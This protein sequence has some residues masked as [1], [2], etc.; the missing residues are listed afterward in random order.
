[1]SLKPLSFFE[2]QAVTDLTAAVAAGNLPAL[3]GFQVEVLNDQV[4]WAKDQLTR[5]A[6][7]LL[8]ATH[9]VAHKKGFPNSDPLVL[10]LTAVV[11][12]GLQRE[13]RDLAMGACCAIADWMR[14]DQNALCFY[15]PADTVLMKIHPEAIA[16]LTVNRVG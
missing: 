15:Q 1:M 2:D 11:P 16:S 3:A 6:K 8:V 7:H 12:G 5:A 4:D 9:A 10:T 13:R 14:T